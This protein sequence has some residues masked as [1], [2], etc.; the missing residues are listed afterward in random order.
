MKLNFWYVV[1]YDETKIGFADMPNRTN[2][3]EVR[4]IC[5]FEGNYVFRH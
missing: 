4:G 2:R 3:G 1:H 5:V